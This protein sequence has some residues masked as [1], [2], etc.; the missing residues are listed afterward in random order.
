MPAS[1]ARKLGAHLVTETME[2]CPDIG[3]ESYDRFFPSQDMM[4]AATLQV[5]QIAECTG[6]VR[7]PSHTANPALCSLLDQGLARV[8]PL[9]I[10]IDVTAWCAAVDR[11]VVPSDRLFA[12]GP[13]TRVAFWE[14]SAVPD[15]R[16]QCAALAAHLR[17]VPGPR[18]RLRPARCFR[19]L[20]RREEVSGRPSGT[21]TGRGSKRPSRRFDDLLARGGQPGQRQNRFGFARRRV[22]R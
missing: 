16:N 21:L 13:L 6:I 15:I 3:F 9:E 12:I 1:D 5:A 4:P 20:N 11:L 19:N 22:Q 17:A 7:N 2:R 14:V 10:G 8:D 18:E